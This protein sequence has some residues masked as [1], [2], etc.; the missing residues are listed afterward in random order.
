MKAAASPDP[1]AVVALATTQSGWAEAMARRCTARLRRSLGER[2]N[3]AQ[4][5]LA[6]GLA[7]PLDVYRAKP[8]ARGQQREGGGGE[9]VVVIDEEL[10]APAAFDG[11]HL[12]VG[13]FHVHETVLMD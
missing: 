9:D 5:V 4:R 3:G 8:R 11:S 12:R 7:Q 1:S 6:A 10:L 13:Y 2:Q